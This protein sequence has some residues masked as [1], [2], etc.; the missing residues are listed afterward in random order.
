ME[1]LFALYQAGILEQEVWQL[2]CGY[3]KALLANP[4]VRESWELDKKNSMF[5]RAFIGSV[6]ETIQKEIPGFM[7][8]GAIEAS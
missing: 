1:A 8:I 2:R 5:T 4:F 7:G 3:M 6:D